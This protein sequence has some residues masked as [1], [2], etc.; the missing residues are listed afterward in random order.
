MEAGALGAAGA[1]LLD[2]LD[3][4]DGVEDELD[5]S[6]FLLALLLE[7]RS[8]YQPPPFRMNAAP[9]EIWRFAVFWLHLGHVSRGSA[10]MRCSSSQTFPQAEQA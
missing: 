6:D 7:Y 3:D 4:V 8:E 1:E 9:P 5:D 2:E 10:V